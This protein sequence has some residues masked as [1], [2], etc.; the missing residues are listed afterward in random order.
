MNFKTS[1]EIE[2]QADNRRDTLSPEDSAKP[3]WTL[4]HQA[5]GDFQMDATEGSGS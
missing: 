4:R 5:D 3:M 1:E 2:T